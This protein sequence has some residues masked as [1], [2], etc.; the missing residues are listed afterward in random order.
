MQSVDAQ[1]IKTPPT[2]DMIKGR[3]ELLDGAS[4]VELSFTAL[5][6]VTPENK[7]NM[8]DYPLS[9]NEK[10]F[11]LPIQFFQITT[12]LQQ[13]VFADLAQNHQ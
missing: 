3:L 6:S 12:H 4:D 13:S 9:M 2:L 1:S 10:F 7:S 5:K 8:K 11:W